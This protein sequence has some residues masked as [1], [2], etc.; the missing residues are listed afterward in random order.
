VEGGPAAASVRAKI[1]AKMTE[2]DDIAGNSSYR[3]K[4]PVMTKRDGMCSEYASAKRTRHLHSRG[5][6][7]E[8]EQ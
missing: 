7:R 4:I 1:R 2:W 8:E 3:A 6:C 5:L